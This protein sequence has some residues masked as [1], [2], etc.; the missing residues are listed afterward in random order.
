MYGLLLIGYT[1][2]SIKEKSSAAEILIATD[3]HTMAVGKMAHLFVIEIGNDLE[4][5]ND[6]IKL[7]NGQVAELVYARDLKFRGLYA[8]EGSTPS[9]V[10]LKRPIP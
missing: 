1:K 5:L 3:A 4:K 8:H 6:N 10:T 9:L 2:Y 7:S